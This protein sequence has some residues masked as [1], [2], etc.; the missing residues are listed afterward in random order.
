M[1]GDLGIQ[2]ELIFPFAGIQEQLAVMFRRKG[3]E[4]SLR[5]WTN[6]SNFS[7]IYT[8]IYDGLV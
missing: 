8:D 7:E 1:D 2:P 6:R 3:F 5:H 4:N